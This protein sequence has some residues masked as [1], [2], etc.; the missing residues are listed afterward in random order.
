MLR[1]DPWN[2]RDCLILL[3]RVTAGLEAAH[4]QGII[5]RDIKPANIFVTS[6]DHAKILDFGLAKL[7]LTEAT[8]AGLPPTDYREDDRFT[9]PIESLTASSPFLSR[10]G[11]AMGTAGYMSPEQIRGETL[12]IRTDL[13]SLGLVLYESGNTA[14]SVFWRNGGGAS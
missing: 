3:F 11:V 1:N 7:F 9:N 6:R 14:T 8:A 10:V 12:D 5:H 4:Q 2:S 13:F